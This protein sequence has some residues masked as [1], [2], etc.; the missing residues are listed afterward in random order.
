MKEFIIRCWRT[1]KHEIEG[2]SSELPSMTIPD[3]SISV[4]ELMYRHQNGLSLGNISDYGNGD[5]ELD[6]DIDDLLDFTELEESMTGDELTDMELVQ[7]EFNN[8]K[9]SISERLNKR[10][11][12]KKKDEKVEE[13]EEETTP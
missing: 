8:K 6:E 3:Q 2:D 7:K 13:T 4:E 10:K 9:R 1:A 5:Y 12:E 11:E